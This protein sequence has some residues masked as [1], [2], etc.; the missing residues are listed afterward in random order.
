VID[1][2]RQEA[3]ARTERLEEE[4]Q[5]AAM[6]SRDRDISEIVR[7]TLTES[8]RGGSEASTWS[9]GG[10]F[11]LGFIGTGFA[12]L[13]GVAGGGGGAS[14][15]AWQNYSRGL[16]ANS[17]QQLRDRTMQSASA[18]RSQRSTVVQTVRQ[19]QSKRV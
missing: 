9:V 6:V 15:S 13:L 2:D 1:W 8:V 14:S 17:L 16:A 10:G 19:G 5:L 7:S 12:G 4:E 11:G 3:A 18:V